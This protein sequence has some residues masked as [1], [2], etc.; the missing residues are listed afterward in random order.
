MTWRNI[1]L[2]DVD[3][4]LHC[5]CTVHT[6]THTRTRIYLYVYYTACRYTRGE[7]ARQIIIL[8]FPGVPFFVVPLLS[9]IISPYV[10]VR[11]GRKKKKPIDGYDRFLVVDR[12][13]IGRRRANLCY[14][15]FKD[16]LIIH[17]NVQNFFSFRLGSCNNVFDILRVTGTRPNR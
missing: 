6:H 11:N 8:L 7:T 15:Q 10:R 13:Q 14:L 16:N 5:L 2:V 9:T 1:A 17:C 12:N 4:L 3:Q